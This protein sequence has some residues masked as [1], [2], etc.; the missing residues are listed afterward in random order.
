MSTARAVLAAL[1]ALATT[2]ASARDEQLVADLVALDRAY[3]DPLFFTSS[4][5]LPKSAQTLAAFSAQW[6]GFSA[7]YRTYRP[8]AANWA[9]HFDAVDEATARAEAIVATARLACLPPAPAQPAPPCP[10]LVP[11]HDALEA[12]R[13]ALRDLRTRNGLPRFTTDQLTAFHGPMEAI[14]LS[15]KDLTADQIT[16]ELLAGLADAIR[17]AD[18]LWSFVERT[19]VDAAWGFTGAQLAA[20]AGRVAAERAAL[21][22]FASAVAAASRAELPALGAAVKQRFVPV[23]TS[24]AADPALNRLP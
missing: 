17:E 6:A 13:F 24:F 5:N 8:D 15:V 9:V 22:A 4:Q 20:I 14:V 11:A 23:Y 10:D 2:T 12:V 19:P 18:L 16:D 3:I 1:L 21:D 7:A